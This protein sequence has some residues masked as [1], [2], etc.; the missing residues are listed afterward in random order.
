MKTAP[1]STLDF[2]TITSREVELH[3]RIARLQREQL[4]TE[5]ELR[6]IR[7]LLS[8]A[9]NDKLTLLSKVRP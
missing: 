2:P 7:R 9:Y 4:E 6:R 5:L 1:S 8:D 3:K